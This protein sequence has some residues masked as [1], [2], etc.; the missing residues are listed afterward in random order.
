MEE[1]RASGLFVASGDVTPR[2]GRERVRVAEIGGSVNCG[3]V[4]VDAGDCVIG[5]ETTIGDSAPL[6]FE[7]LSPSRKNSRSVTAL[8]NE[9]LDAGAEVEVVAG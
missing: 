9:P 7:R 6:D 5:D 4:T 2:S 3:G 1:I 8:L